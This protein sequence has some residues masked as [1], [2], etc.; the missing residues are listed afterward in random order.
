MSGGIDFFA[1]V[2]A[3]S[4]FFWGVLFLAVL[5]GGGVYLTVRL[6]FFQL[7]YMPYIIKETFGK[8]FDKGK[9]KG[10]V[11]PFQA[12]ANPGSHSAPCR[13]TTLPGVVRTFRLPGKSWAGSR[14]SCSTMD[15]AGQS[16][17]L[18]RP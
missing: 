10:T 3:I 13:P 5:V 2:G 1:V 7:R 12:A 9:G 8:V 15:S 14:M 6:G 11:S 16:N 17:I 18:G 4:G